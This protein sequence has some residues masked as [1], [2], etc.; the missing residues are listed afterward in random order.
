MLVLPTIFLS[1]EVGAGIE[2]PDL[3]KIITVENVRQEHHEHSTEE[4]F[5]YCPTCGEWLKKK[6][7][8]IRYVCSD[9]RH[10]IPEG[11]QF[12]AFCG[13]KFTGASEEK[14]AFRRSLSDEEFGKATRT[15][16]GPKDQKG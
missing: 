1:L 11:S 2:M 3:V 10:F 6:Q 12:C 9:C 13:V 14:W 5:R 15:I 4:H 7:I 16:F 8:I